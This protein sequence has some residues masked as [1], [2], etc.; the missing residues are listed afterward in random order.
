MTWSNTF[1]EKDSETTVTIQISFDKEEDIQKI[2][3]LGFIEG[4]IAALE[5]LD[6]LLK[7]Y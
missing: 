6:E 4:F 2:I 1:T 5:N 3:D 7:E